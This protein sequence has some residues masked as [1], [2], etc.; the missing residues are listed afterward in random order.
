MIQLLNCKFIVYHELTHALVYQYIPLLPSH[1]WAD[2][3]LRSDP[4][5]M[6]EAWADYFAA[7]HCGISNFKDKTYNKRPGRNLNNDLTCQN[8]VGEVHVDSQI[9]SGA[10]WQIRLALKS[11]ADRFAFDQL[12]L[13]S[14]SLGHASDLFA[15]QFQIVLDLL[16]KDD[17]LSYIDQLALQIFSYRE[18]YCERIQIIEEKSDVTFQLPSN[19]I[20]VVNISTLP[21]Q[22]KFLPR[23]S[24]W[25]ASFRWRQWSVSGWLGKTDLGFA[26]MPLQ[27]LISTCPIRVSGTNFTNIKAFSNC[28]NTLT[29]LEWRSSKYSNLFGSI[30]FDILPDSSPIYMVIGSTLPQPIIMY[31]S[32]LTFYGYNHI[33]RITLIVFSG[34]YLILFLVASGTFIKTLIQKRKDLSKKIGF[35]IL[36]FLLYTIPGIFGLFGIIFGII[37]EIFTIC[38]FGVLFMDLLLSM[39]LV[40]MRF[41]LKL[42]SK[43]PP[44]PFL[45][46]KCFKVDTLVEKKWFFI[47]DTIF[48]IEVIVSFLLV[49]SYTSTVLAHSILYTLFIF[50]AL[51]HLS[52]IICSFLNVVFSDSLQ[53]RDAVIPLENVNIPAPA[54]L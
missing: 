49:I 53:V 45:I 9:F 52:F 41:N 22:L 7:I 19:S 36:L 28:S 11:E 51:L 26:K 12:V 6:N 13:R 48:M 27:A 42:A 1:T 47:I 30:D 21:T 20:T 44:V 16:S 3:G 17:Q 23:K 10:L 46:S 24:D 35:F 8:S 25:A 2:T 50:L 54:E 4:G 40:P 14:I 31:S 39:F 5:A 18:F 15:T 29:E 33:W 32:A 37:R 34:F 38:M 43:L